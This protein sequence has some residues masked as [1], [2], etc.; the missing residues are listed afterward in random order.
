MP[1]SYRVCVALCFCY[2]LID[3]IGSTV[4]NTVKFVFSPLMDELLR[5]GI[6]R[7]DTVLY[8][9]GGTVVQRVERWTCDL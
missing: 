8:L 2:L 6:F 9:V 4:L 1:L 7:Q 5:F 3:G